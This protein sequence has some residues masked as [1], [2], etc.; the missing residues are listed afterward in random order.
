MSFNEALEA[1]RERPIVPEAPSIVYLPKVELGL[2][3]NPPKVKGIKKKKKI[4][5]KKW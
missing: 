1:L 4:K 2:L 3:N 5:K